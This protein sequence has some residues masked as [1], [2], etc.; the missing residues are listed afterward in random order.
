MPLEVRT[1]RAALDRLYRTSSF[2]QMTAKEAAGDGQDLDEVDERGKEI[3]VAEP[4]APLIP[5]AT[6]PRGARAGN[7]FHDLFEH[8]DFQ[9]PTEIERMVSAKLRGHGYDENAWLT[10]VAT[11]VRAVLDTPL[12]E[13][14]LKLAD[15]PMRA[16]VNELEFLLP[17]AHRTDRKTVLPRDLAE[18]FETHPDGLPPGYADRLRRLPF[19]PLRGFLKGF[20]DLVFEHE[21]RLWIV[22][23][24][25]NHLGNTRASYDASALASVM[26]EHHYL[27]QAHLYTVAVLR[28]V[29][30]N[31][32]ELDYD[33]DFG[34]VLYLFLRGMSPEGGWAFGVYR[35]KPPV[36]RIE[37][38][39][40]LLDTAHDP[41][42][43]A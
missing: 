32:P 18:A 31:R 2:T 36:A 16:R 13:P 28:H 27:L 17:V 11:A 1:P 25:T 7:F 30:R 21:G 43:A 12:A 3:S 34:G 37:A 6:F 9:A 29:R 39:S 33:R 42:A 35:D 5:L 40:A 41:E 38:I 20:I 26:A 8:L 10:P 4:D 24:K 15:V 22:D 23:Y 19:T 14:G